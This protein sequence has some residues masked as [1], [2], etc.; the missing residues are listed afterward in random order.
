MDAAAGRTRI[1]QR[2]QQTDEKET[3]SHNK[4]TRCTDP[5]RCSV[6]WLTRILSFSLFLSPSPSGELLWS[7]GGHGFIFHI[8]WF[9]STGLPMFE[10][11]FR[12]LLLDGYPAVPF[13]FNC[14]KQ[15]DRHI[16][17]LAQ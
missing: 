9:K 13:Y 17:R 16:G 11:F 12:L 1:L 14:A 15:S 6:F 4:H 7:H 5:G 3:G 10:D 8:Y 2:T